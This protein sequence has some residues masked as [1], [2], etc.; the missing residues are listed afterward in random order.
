[1]LVDA[2]DVLISQLAALAVP[3]AAFTIVYKLK[4][5]HPRY[6][7]AV[8]FILGGAFVLELVGQLAF[9]QFV[10]ERTEWRLKQEGVTTTA[11]ILSSWK[12]G[13]ASRRFRGHLNWVSFYD[14]TVEYADR[15]GAK[16][17]G[18]VEVGPAVSHASGDTVSVRY[19]PSEPT[20][21]REEVYVST[22]KQPP[23]KLVFA[24]LFWGWDALVLSWIFLRARK[25]KRRA[26]KMGRTDF[27][28]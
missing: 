25:K 26:M 18:L 5:F 15:N 13:S 7:Q 22:A 12:A 21:M 8:L 4:L 17:R 14:A 20:A 11:R 19:L 9:F 6:R 27:P 10:E 3:A 28:Y 2:L 24:S 23:S 1:M 16:Y